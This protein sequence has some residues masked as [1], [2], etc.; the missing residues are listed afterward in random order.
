MSENAGTLPPE[1]ARRA[2]TPGQ[3]V[4]LGTDD[5]PCREVTCGQD[6]YCVPGNGVAACQCNPGFEGRTTLVETEQWP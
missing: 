2:M 6:S 4:S 3:V 1:E 5:D